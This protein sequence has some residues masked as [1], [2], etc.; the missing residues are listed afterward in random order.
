MTHGSV[1]VLVPTPTV[2][3]SLACGREGRAASRPGLTELA[4][5]RAA[6]NA[7]K[8]L[9]QNLRWSPKTGQ[10]AKRESSLERPVGRR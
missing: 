9:E 10:A 8:P 7:A 6:V 4:G 5:C 2:T 3:T 1:K